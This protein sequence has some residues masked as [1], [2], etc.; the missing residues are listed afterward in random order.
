MTAMHTVEIT[1][2][3]NGAMQR[4]DI[5]A[6]ARG[7]ESFGG[8][9]HRAISLLRSILMVRCIFRRH[10]RLLGVCTVTVPLRNFQINGLFNR[11]C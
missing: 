5:L 10:A 1:D 6:I 7:M 2:C 8:F 3:H 4:P 11:Y 9:V